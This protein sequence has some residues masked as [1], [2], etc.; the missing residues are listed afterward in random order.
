MLPLLRNETRNIALN[1]QEG[2]RCAG[3][4]ACVVHYEGTQ[5]CRKQRKCTL[6]QSLYQLISQ[7]TSQPTNRSLKEI[8]VRKGGTAGVKGQLVLCPLLATNS[9]CFERRL[10][11]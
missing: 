1:A 5:F 8:K 6:Y 11:V 7:P 3:L 2:L 4:A 9:N 10:L